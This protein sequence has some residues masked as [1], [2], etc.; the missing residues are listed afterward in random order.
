MSGQRG[1][2]QLTQSLSL[3]HHVGHCHRHALSEAADRAIN[4]R[5]ELFQLGQKLERVL[6]HE[7]VLIFLV[8]CLVRLLQAIVMDLQA[9][10]QV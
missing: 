6:V 2:E 5:L 4:A 8:V 7:L 1:L 3:T 9:L 10:A